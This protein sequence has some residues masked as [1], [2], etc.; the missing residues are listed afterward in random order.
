MRLLEAFIHLM[1]NRN[2]RQL[3]SGGIPGWLI[4]RPASRAWMLDEEYAATRGPVARRQYLLPGQ[5]S[6]SIT[7]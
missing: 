5:K 3:P 7:L 4:L 2:V 6:G 1:P